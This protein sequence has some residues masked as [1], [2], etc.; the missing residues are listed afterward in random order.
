MNIPYTTKFTLKR[1]VEN[2]NE[3]PSNGLG[4][5]VKKLTPEQKTRL[6][7]LVSTFESFG[8]CLQNEEAIVN[9]ARGLQELAQLAK[10]YALNEC[11][12][13]FQRN[14]VEKDMKELEKR[15]MEH[16]KIATEC[17]ARM[18][19]LGVSYQDIG[20]ILGRYYDLKSAKKMDQHYTPAEKQ[21][22]QS[23]DAMGAM[24]EADMEEDLNRVCSWCKK[25]LGTTPSNQDGDT[26]GICPE[27]QKEFLSTTNSP[28]AKL[29]T[30][31]PHSKH[32][33]K[34]PS[35]GG[36]KG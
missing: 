32:D 35:S 34:N 24:M 20:H 13:C 28:F 36:W 5:E 23:E 12:E 2:L 10:Q 3:M 29:K 26:H 11:S 4:P 6:M 33:I 14:I 27:C 16:S 15:I 8:E 18:Q 19:Q 30:M 31:V 1:I 25:K 9:S 7:E 22:L 17:Y 21:P